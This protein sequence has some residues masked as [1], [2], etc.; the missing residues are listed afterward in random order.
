MFQNKAIKAHIYLNALDSHCFYDFLVSEAHIYLIA[1]DAA[2]P[3]LSHHQIE[4]FLCECLYACLP[5]YN[6]YK[7]RN[8]P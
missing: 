4:M 2:M 5:A 7:F 1:C 3:L 8:V 6:K